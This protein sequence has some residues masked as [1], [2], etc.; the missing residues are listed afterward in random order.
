MIKAA[1]LL[2]L[3]SSARG[4]AGL[5]AAPTLRRPLS[6]RA[7]GMGDAFTAVE[8]G[9]SSLGHNAAALAR[10]EKPE[11][12]ATFTRGIIEDKFSFA[13]YAH[14]LSGM[15][16]GAG[17]LYY[18]AGTIRIK[19]TAGAEESRKAQQDFVGLFSAAAPL[20]RLSVGGQLKAMRLTLAGTSASG[21]AADLGA[22][23]R[24]PLP[25]LTLGASALNLGPDVKFESEGDPLPMT[26]RAGAAWGAVIDPGENFAFSQFTFTGDVV[27]VRDEEVRPSAGMEMGMRIV[28]QGIVA[29][30]FGYLFNRELDSF[31][32]GVGLR[33]GRYSLDYAIGVMRQISHAHHLTFGLSF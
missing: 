24:S 18:D 29:L 10:I 6:A 3:A 14:P 11:A 28:D 33:D 4:E 27:K 23:W 17:L 5:T 16:L 22:Q 25:G 26:L 8:G 15:V 9:L 7:V 19:T 13:S 12:R 32:A 1:L 30:R 2:F 31:T 20:G 21:A